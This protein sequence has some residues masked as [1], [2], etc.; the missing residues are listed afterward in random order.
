M[1]PQHTWGILIIF[2]R[3]TCQPKKM[4]ARLSARVHRAWALSLWTQGS[5]SWLLG[6]S[7]RPWALR[8]EHEPMG[9]CR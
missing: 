7:H 4:P 9:L 5:K 1:E 2:Q 3:K 8:P 6:Q